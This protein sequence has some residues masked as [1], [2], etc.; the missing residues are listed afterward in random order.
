MDT[1]ILYDSNKDTLYIKIYKLGEGS[2]AEVWCC[3]EIPKLLYLTT[4][5]KDEPLKL[6]ITEIF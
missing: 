3:I 6:N 5:Y 4:V 2:Y 1:N